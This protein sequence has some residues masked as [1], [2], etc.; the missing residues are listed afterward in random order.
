[1]GAVFFTLVLLTG[2][3]MAQAVR[4]RIPELA[5]LK[6]IGFSNK[7]VLGLV[8]SESVLLLLL[9]GAIGLAVA[10]VVVG[11]VR[12]KL[13][14]TVPLAPVGGPIWLRG[15][16]LMVVIGFIVGVLP[17]IRGMRLRIVDA[18]SGR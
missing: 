5:V 4:E 10:G 15:V 18:L 8:L 11:I 12:V 6:T 13:G 2:N 7:S 3:T 1:M 9:G 17:A 16:A 14:A